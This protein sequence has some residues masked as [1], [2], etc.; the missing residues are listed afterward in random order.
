[1]KT[2]LH[3][4]L[5]Y[6]DPAHYNGWDGRLVAC[7]K[8][9]QDM[10]VLAHRAGYQSTV[11]NDKQATA[12]RITSHITAVSENLR[13]G[14]TFL[15]TYSGHGGQVPDTNGDERYDRGPGGT[16]RM[17]ETWCTWDRQLIDDELHYLWSL[18]KR[19]V[20][21]LVLSDSCHSGTMARVFRDDGFYL[22]AV[23]SAWRPRMMS[24]QRSAAV[25]KQNK[26][27]YEGIQSAVPTRGK[28]RV[29]ASV[30]L[31]SGCQDN[32]YSLDGDENGLFTG[33]LLR[34]LSG[35]NVP[36]T[37]QSLR[38]YIARLMPPYQTPNFFKVGRTSAEFEG[39][40]PLV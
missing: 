25:Y 16:S 18:F 28:S 26:A 1:M 14:D 10:Q 36:T 40:N 33:T 6:V 8:D 38:D 30:V 29:E 7:I 24:N 34:V 11:L 17:D 21:I 23:G 37:L 19:G 2:S 15:I 3:I 27:L 5:N 35:E 13:A 39:Q 9:S 12:S 22:A 32:Q 4:G 20:R 31:I